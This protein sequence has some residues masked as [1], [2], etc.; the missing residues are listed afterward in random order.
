M[1]NERGGGM[2]NFLVRLWDSSSPPLDFESVFF[3]LLFTLKV[4]GLI[5]WWWVW[6][7][8]PLWAPQVVVWIAGVI[9]RRID[10]RR[11]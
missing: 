6:I 8:A 5:D 2:R 10:R 7:F 9:L 3:L 11:M 4:T 1:S